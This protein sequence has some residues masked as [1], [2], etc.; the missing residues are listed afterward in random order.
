MRVVVL[1]VRTQRMKQVGLVPNQCAVEQFVAAGLDHLSMI[2][3]MR[4]MRTPVSTTVIPDPKG[5]TGQ[6]GPAGP[7]GPQG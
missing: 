2:A 6:S 3:F 1:L 7:L 5:D 4:G